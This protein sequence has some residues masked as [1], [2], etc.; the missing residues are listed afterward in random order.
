MLS[1]LSLPPASPSENIRY[2]RRHFPARWQ[3][4]LHSAPL[5]HW[6]RPL[7][8]A[9][10]PGD[11]PCNPSAPGSWTLEGHKPSPGTPPPGHIQT[12]YPWDCIPA[13]APPPLPCAIR[14]VPLPPLP[15]GGTGTASCPPLHPSMEGCK[16]GHEAVPVPPEG[17]GGRGTVRMAQGRGGG[18]GAGIQSHGYPVWIW[19]GGG[20]PGEGLCPSRVQE[21]GADGLQGLSPGKDACHKGRCQCGR[22]AECKNSYRR[23]GKC[24][25]SYRIFSEGEAGGRDSPLSLAWQCRYYGWASVGGERGEAQGGAGL[26]L[27]KGDL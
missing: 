26:D 16:G 2:E 12:G 20:V 11:S 8:P 13:P 4:F 18:A 22:G 17:K 27:E 15:S 7:W 9:S 6:Q 1:G 5:P 14:T 24:L 3:E 10:F 23:A 19:P 21:P 25:F